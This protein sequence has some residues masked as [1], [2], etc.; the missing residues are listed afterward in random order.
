MPSSR[1][2]GTS[3][4]STARRRTSSRL[5]A[6]GVNL[7]EGTLDD[8]ASLEAAIPEG[9][10]RRLPRRRQHQPLVEER[11]AA[12]QGQRG[13]HEQRR[14]RR[15]RPQGEALR[16]YLHPSPSGACSTIS[17]TTRPA[18]SAASTR[19]IN[20]QRS[21]HLG[22]LEVRKAIERGPRRRDPNPSHIVGR[23]DTE[24]W[25]KSIRLVA[26]GK[27]PGIP[28]GKGSFCDAGAVAR[29]HVA[30]VDRAEDR[31]ELHPR[32]RR[33]DVPGAGDDHRR[34]ARKEG[35]QERRPAMDHL[36]RERA[37]RLRLALHRASQ[38]AVTPEM[39]EGLR[40]H[41]IVSCEKAVEGARLREGAAADDARDGAGV[42]GGRGESMKNPTPP[43][44]RPAG[45][46]GG[47]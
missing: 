20:Y 38:P 16:P 7:A 22:E 32:R 10:R 18:R 17:R 41:E 34:A 44:P 19:T 14:Q 39:V 12:D 31:R 6:R 3:S 46:A 40:H 11:R 4:P 29:A 36:A 26:E 47:A 1:P 37:H 24:G 13:R 21:K 30:A 15:A 9:A 5:R 25:S 33:R 35:R 28:P 43:A 45:R 42:A 23:Y 8:R 2:A 27:L